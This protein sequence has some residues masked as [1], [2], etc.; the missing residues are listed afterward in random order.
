MD[1][2][3]FMKQVKKEFQSNAGNSRVKVKI[4]IIFYFE[5]LVYLY[6]LIIT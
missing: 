1:H 5:I 3:G 6:A 4:F 2:L